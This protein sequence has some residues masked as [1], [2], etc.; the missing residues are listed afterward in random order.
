M[1]VTFLS[2]K[3]RVTINCD[4]GEKLLHAGLRQ[5]I[6]LPYECGTGLCG[7]CV[8]RAK[9]GTIEPGWSAAPGL[10]RLR[11]AKGEFLL[12]QCSPIKDCDIL[13]PGQSGLSKTISRNP[14]HQ[15]GLLHNFS[16]VAP[17]VATINLELNHELSFFSG[18][19]VLMRLDGMDGYR[20]YS[21][22]NYNELTKK[23]K[24]VVKKTSDGSFTEFLFK[25]QTD[26]IECDVFGPMGK[27]TFDPSEKRNLLC[28]VGGSGIAGI[29]SILNHAQSIEYFRERKAC[30]VF[31]VR[32]CDDFFFLQE[33]KDIKD[34][35]PDKIEIVLAVSDEYKKQV[36]NIFGFTVFKGFVNEVLENALAGHFSDY[37]AFLGGPTAMVNSTLPWLF[38]SGFPSER[39]RYDK[40]G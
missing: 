19:Y 21:M 28:I 4:A 24:F 12:C 39:I 26:S 8:A 20:A 7:T 33:L 38:K 13:V 35:A 34:S 15:R 17:E 27:A 5:G 25:H 18:Q 3:E 14:L 10:K 40:F 11:L 36:K 32:T 22:T 16:Y 30:I 9:P 23:L 31:G 6:F 2:R 1:K 29:M 37:I